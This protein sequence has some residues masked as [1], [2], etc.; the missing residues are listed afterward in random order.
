MAWGSTNDPGLTTSCDTDDG[1]TDT[2]NCIGVTAC[3]LNANTCDSDNAYWGFDIHDNVN[4]Y[5]DY[6]YCCKMFT[7]GQAARMRVAVQ[8]ANT[9]RANLWSSANLIATGANGSLYLCKA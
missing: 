7:A 2:P 6:S 4:N 3:I 9:G 1:V 5:M 8:Q